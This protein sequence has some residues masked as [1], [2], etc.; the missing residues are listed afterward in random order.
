MGRL[1]ALL[2]RALFIGGLCTPAGSC[3][4]NAK[5]VLYYGYKTWV[6]DGYQTEIHARDLE[7]GEDK[8]VFVLRGTGY[9]NFKAVDDG[10]AL[11]YGW[12]SARGKEYRV[13]KALRGD[14]SQEF[15][16]TMEFESGNIPVTGIIYDETDKEIYINCHNDDEPFSGRQRYYFAKIDVTG[17]RPSLKVIKE[18]PTPLLILKVIGVC[19]YYLKLGQAGEELFY[20][21]S[22]TDEEGFI[23]SLPPGSLDGVVTD[24]ISFYIFSKYDKAERRKKVFCIPLLKGVGDKGVKNPKYVLPLGY[25]LSPNGYSAYLSSIIFHGVRSKGAGSGVTWSVRSLNTENWEATDLF[26]VD[27]T[28]N[29]RP[30]IVGWTE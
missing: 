8:T 6:G 29:T 13:Y 24:D 19:I 30:Y 14:V 18:S 27:F 20:Y 4:V 15:A 28:E 2:I 3:A 10:R 9:Y 23:G 26:E 12:V 5:G 21:N 7:N 25:S 22:F 11:I 16:V 17:R 1:K